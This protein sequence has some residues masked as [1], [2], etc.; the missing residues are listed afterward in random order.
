[1]FAFLVAA[2]AYLVMRRL[3]RRGPALA[4]SAATLVGGLI[5][6]ELAMIAA[7]DGMG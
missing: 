3:I 2:A 6:A 1:V 5:F 4:V 7:L